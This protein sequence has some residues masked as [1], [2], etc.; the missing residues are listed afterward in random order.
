MKISDLPELTELS[1]AEYLPIVSNG[2]T[3][4][5]AASLLG[6]NSP[7]VITA[8]PFDDEFDGAALDSSWVWT[9]QGIST[10]IVGNGKLTLEKA[11]DSSNGSFS[12]L[13]KAAPSAP[14][15]EMT[16]R[17]TF[18]GG[19]AHNTGQGLMVGANNGRLMPWFSIAGPSSQ[20]R[21][22]ARFNS[23]SSY[24]GFPY[25][26]GTADGI[27]ALGSVSFF[28]VAV[29]PS[30][31]KFHAA[32]E[33]ELLSDPVSLFYTENKTTFLPSV[34]RVGFTLD[35]RNSAAGLAVDWVKFTEG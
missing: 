35:S 32:L 34:D 2:T 18:T 7:E 20:Q 28:R 8:H 3:Y 16:A 10:A 23:P 19:S 6:A 4:K 12:S 1:G 13:Y 29:T 22:V 21:G 26:A 33:E 15:W 14:E 11:P 31:I 30:Q 17:L 25:A 24:S 9:N 5:I 27:G